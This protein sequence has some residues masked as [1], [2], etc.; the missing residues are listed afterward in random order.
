MSEEKTMRL[1]QVARKLNVATPVIIA[2]LAEKG[3]RLENNPNTKITPEQY[4][5]LAKEFADAATDKEEAAELVIGQ[6]YE[7]GFKIPGSKTSIR[8][9]SSI[10][11]QAFRPSLVPA[12]SQKKTSRSSDVLPSTTD[13]SESIS[14][15]SADLPDHLTLDEAKQPAASPL[16]AS[17][18]KKQP[19]R[20]GDPSS[21]SAAPQVA[22]PSANTPTITKIS[23]VDQEDIKGIT[24]VGKIVL[25]EKDKS[26][27]N[28]HSVASSDLEK[29]SSKRPRKRLPDLTVSPAAPATPATTTSAG[30]Q[31][32]MHKSRYQPGLR[33]H[34][35]PKVVVSEK[36]IQEKIKH[37]LA[38]LSG[39]KTIA[40]RIKYRREKRS[41]F[42]EEQAA[43]QL[44]AT[45]D[46]KIL[47]V[48]EFIAASDLASLMGTPINDLLS[49]CM[50][51]GILVSINQRLDAEVITI[52]AHEFG[53]QINF[54]D[55]KSQEVEESQEIDPSTLV[56]RPPIVT[57]MGHVDHGK[58]S[59]L[60][61]IR[62]TQITKTEAGGITQHI[63]AYDVLTKSGKRI[64]FLDTPGHEAFTAM[65]ARGVR[66]TDIAVIVIAADDGVKPQT[67]EAINHAKLAGL[68]LVIAINKI[69]KPDANPER[70]K[71]EL[72]HLNILVE[73]WGG[74][75]QVQGV[76][77]LTGE[78]VDGL[79]EKILFEAELLEL[80]ANP[81]KKARGTVVEA[82]LDQGRGYLATVMIQ[83]GTLHHGE[84]VLAGAHYGKIKALFDYQGK[85]IKEAPPSTPVQILG[86]NGAPQAGDVFVVMSSEREARAVAIH[87]Q[88]I[89]R[90]QGLRT[91]THITLDEIGR[92]LAIGH[93]KELNLIIKGDVDGSVEALAGSLLQLSTEEVK[94]NVIYKGVGAVVESDVLLAAASDAIIIGFQVR[95][96]T[97]VR[98]L[99]EREGVE[100]RLYAIIYDAINHIKD[101][102]QGML[103][104]TIEEVITGV[105]TV[106]EIF[107][108]TG[109]GLVA[110]CS[111]TE[112]IIKRNSDIRVIRDGI[113]IYTG[114]VKY[115]KHF[116]ED[117]QQA[118]TGTE[119]GIH[120]ANF[121]DIKVGDSLEGFEK[122]TIERQR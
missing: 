59:L 66:L 96:S 113:V 13:S 73:D 28:F 70:V 69:D 34:A 5:V 46:L 93:F 43:E 105:A 104:P 112:G 50:N 98:K 74:K 36:E 119:C 62:N 71:Q 117:I 85:N 17:I 22:Q 86:L 57:I 72:A 53:Y 83:D 54:T 122:K 116:K 77:A 121:N 30:L 44:Q 99:A 82:S 92:R 84:I 23:L 7:A 88:Q 32:S 68:P 3:F 15:L 12:P 39:N 20:K 67:K 27:K 42:A 16:K 63:G 110:G 8:S 29:R 81:N 89:L 75:H 64:A 35:S 11:P 26:A 10:K 1:S 31:P 118:K 49:V 79:L 111:V 38:K 65:R 107:K 18:P 56:E 97:N 94:I 24:V 106:R 114:T 37:T 102:I 14:A 4:S 60:D 80:K 19:E 95:P 51:L 45:K 40:N 91:R 48:T 41:L 115:L 21:T 33:S 55:V 25:A 6:S 47:H 78:G 2:Y 61:Y 76:S 58:T 87:R 90:E 108:I 120:I 109:I 103:A 9:E 101:A 52:I 100:I